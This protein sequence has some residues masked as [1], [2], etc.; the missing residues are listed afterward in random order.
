MVEQPLPRLSVYFLVAPLGVVAIET[1]NGLQQL[2]TLLHQT[3]IGRRSSTVDWLFQ[4]WKASRIR[5]ASGSPESST[6]FQAWLKL[7]TDSKNPMYSNVGLIQI[8][9]AHV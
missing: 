3:G 5:V 9:R 4:L 8:G 1:G 7:L 2:P 6:T